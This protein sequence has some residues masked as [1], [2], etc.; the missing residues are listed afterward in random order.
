MNGREHV[1]DQDYGHFYDTDSMMPIHDCDIVHGNRIYIER[2]HSRDYATEPLHKADKEDKDM[3]MDMNLNLITENDCDKP[4][5][6]NAKHFI[7]I[8][9]LVTTSLI[10]FECWVFYGLGI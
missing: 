9:G 5:R 3:N 1:D 2:R 6:I 10:L 4:S 8:L 7:C